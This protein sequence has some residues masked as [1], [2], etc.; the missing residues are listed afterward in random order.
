MHRPDWEWEPGAHE[1]D[2][3]C[4]TTRRVME[5]GNY[6]KYEVKPVTT[7]LKELF[8]ISTNWSPMNLATG[9]DPEKYKLPYTAGDADY[10]P[11]QPVHEA[12]TTKLLRKR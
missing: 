7:N 1:G 4:R 5:V 10:L 12:S 6:Y 11:A 2:G 3:W 8:P 9:L